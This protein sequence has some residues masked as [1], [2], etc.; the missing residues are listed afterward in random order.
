L[1]NTGLPEDPVDS[2]EIDP[3]YNVSDTYMGDDDDEA[4]VEDT[5]VDDDDDHIDDHDDN[6]DD[7]EPV[8]G[9]SECH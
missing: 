5:E 6:D 4:D 2:H 3:Y 8:A 9:S 1:Q 7:D